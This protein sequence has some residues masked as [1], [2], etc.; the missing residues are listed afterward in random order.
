M[1]PQGTARVPRLLASQTLEL[2]SGF[3]SLLPLPASFLWLQ[4]KVCISPQTR[5]AQDHPWEPQRTEPASAAVLTFLPHGLWARA[6]RA[7]LTLLSKPKLSSPNIRTAGS[8]NPTRINLPWVPVFPDPCPP[9]LCFLSL[10]LAKRTSGVQYQ[11]RPSFSYFALQRCVNEFKP[12]GQVWAVFARACDS[13]LPFLGTHAPQG[14]CET[15]CSRS[16]SSDP[17]WKLPTRP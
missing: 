16:S 7:S 13:A 10:L 9:L 6:R 12:P 17:N 14:M 15:V 3:L 11:Q 5:G 4:R 1:P 8:R 2:E